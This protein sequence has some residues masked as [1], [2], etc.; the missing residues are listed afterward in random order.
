MTLPRPE[1][2]NRLHANICR[3]LADPKRIR[4]LYTLDLKPRH[5]SALA[6]DLGIPQPTVSRHLGILR[7]QSLVT[8]ERDGPSMVYRVADERI[9]DVLNTV[10][11]L[12]FESMAHQ[13]DF[14]ETGAEMR[15]EIA[16]Q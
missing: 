7:R 16:R 13:S 3:A 10:R 9:I 12:M 14:I 2:L 5:V 1:D 8:A 15:E 6:E 11:I 4:I